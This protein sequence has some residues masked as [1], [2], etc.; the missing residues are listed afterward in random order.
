MY[1]FFYSFVLQK[2][3]YWQKNLPTC[4]FSCLTYS[5]ILITCYIAVFLF[6]FTGICTL[7]TVCIYPCTVMLLVIASSSPGSG[8]VLMLFGLQF[9]LLLLL[10]NC[11]CFLLARSFITRAQSHRNTMLLYLPLLHLYVLLWDKETGRHI[12]VQIRRGVV[13][14]LKFM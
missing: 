2:K 7:V 10:E 11:F 9:V 4:I 1:N 5:Y 12:Y 8:D 14:K 3:T 6:F 13:S